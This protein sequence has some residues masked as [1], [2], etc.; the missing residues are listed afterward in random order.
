MKIDKSKVYD[1]MSGKIIKL[2]SILPGLHVDTLAVAIKLWLEK[3]RTDKKIDINTCNPF[4]YINATNIKAG[5]NYCEKVNMPAEYLSKDFDKSSN[6]EN[7]KKYIEIGFAFI[8]LS[9]M[10]ENPKLEKDKVIKKSKQIC[11]EKFEE[12]K[13]YLKII[14]NK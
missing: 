5:R 8:A 1:K 10:K 14:N 3:I 11:F 4:L 13:Q 2:M 9:I 12:Y 6:E 7:I